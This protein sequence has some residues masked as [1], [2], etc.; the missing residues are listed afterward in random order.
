MI[1]VEETNLRGGG[2][3][4]APHSRILQ[5]TSNIL[6]VKWG[7]QD[8]TFIP[9]IADNQPTSCHSINKGTEYKPENRENSVGLLF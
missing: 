4:S 8:E 2:E 5:S 6:T 9:N 1:C 3:V 7:W